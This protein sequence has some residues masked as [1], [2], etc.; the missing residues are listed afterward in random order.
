MHFQ[1]LSFHIFRPDMQPVTNTIPND[2][3]LSFCG[4]DLSGR[5]GTPRINHNLTLTLYLIFPIITLK[6]IKA[7]LKAFQYNILCAAKLF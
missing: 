1:P 6:H 5:H 3:Y 7:V 2:T 4:N